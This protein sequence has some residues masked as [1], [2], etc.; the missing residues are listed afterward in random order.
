MEKR[1]IDRLRQRGYTS[2]QIN[3]LQAQSSI[4]MQ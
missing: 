4:P 3:M 1:Q 2:Q